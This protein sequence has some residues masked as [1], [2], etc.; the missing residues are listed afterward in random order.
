MNKITLR[1]YNREI[2][3]IT[4]QG[5]IDEAIAHCRHILKYFPKHVETYRLLGK[6]YL[7]NQRL[8]DAADIFQRVL[9][10]VPDDFVAHIG[11]SIIREDEGNLD[12]AIWHMQRAFDIQSAN[13]TIQDELRRL[14]GKRDGI[15]PPKIRLS[16]AALAR[17]YAQGDLVDQAI[18]DLRGALLEEPERMDLLVLL[19][20][21][22][23]ANGQRVKTA[24]TCSQIINKLPYC[25]EANLIL[26]QVLSETNRA[27]EAAAHLEK[28]RELD[29]YVAYLSTQAPTLDLVPEAAVSLIK[30]DDSEIR[31]EAASLQNKPAWASSLGMEVKAETDPQDS[32]DWLLSEDE[33]NTG[34]DDNLEASLA[35]SSAFGFGVAVASTSDEMATPDGDLLDFANNAASEEVIPDWMKEAGWEPRDPAK[36]EEN[37]VSLSPEAPVPPPSDNGD[38]APAEIPAWLQAMA[39]QELTGETA[40]QRIFPQAPRESTPP[41]TPSPNLA[42]TD[43]PDWL[44]AMENKPASA[45]EDDLDWLTNLTS[46]AT[47]TLPEAGV[48]PEAESLPDWLTD[49][50]RG[51]APEG[52]APSTSDLPDWLTLTDD[53]TS[54]ETPPAP[55]SAPDPTWFEGTKTGTWDTD[56]LS[57]TGITSWLEQLADTE[58]PPAPAE[59]ETED[60]FAPQAGQTQELALPK[61]ADDA[62]AIP[63]WLQGLDDALITSNETAEPGSPSPAENQPG[64]IPTDHIPAWLQGLDD[65]ILTSR[66]AAEDHPQTEVD[67]NQDNEMP[68]LPDMEDADAALR[69]LESLA[70]N[71]GAREE[72]LL[73]QPADRTSA[74][75]AWVQKMADDAN[76][77]D[78]LDWDA[79]PAEMEE[80]AKE[81]PVETGVPDWLSAEIDSEAEEDADAQDSGLAWLEGLAASQTNAA[82]E[83]LMPASD[84]ASGDEEADDWLDSL[85]DDVPA[86]DVEATP[87]GEDVPDWLKDALVDSGEASAEAQLPSWLADV[88]IEDDDEDV[89]ETTEEEAMPADIPDWLQQTMISS[90]PLPSAAEETEPLDDEMAAPSWL[91]TE[92]PLEEYA[93]MSATPAEDEIEDEMADL[94]SGEAP[95]ELEPTT[96]EEMPWELDEEEDEKSAEPSWL[97]EPM[98]D[99]PAE[100][101]PWSPGLTM[102]EED[103]PDME[104]VVPEPESRPS[105]DDRV[106]I[107]LNEAR[108]ALADGNIDSALIGYSVMIKKKDS[109]NRVIQDLNEALQYKHPVNVD[110]WQTLGDA[111]ARNEELQEALNAYTKAEELLR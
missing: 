59:P 101:I 1:G 43:L 64:G 29:P 65:E 66:P 87:I 26:S 67:M 10:A 8:G 86:G 23:R 50:D 33:T 81:M 28:A 25:L 90:A 73:T 110:I 72:E 68:E 83:D 94:W 32:V 19:A 84:F 46:K 44:S 42:G 100:T 48:T 53:D 58:P 22:Y 82:A 76:A 96:Q 47:A 61:P 92:K 104:E 17:M 36:P 21:M 37:P 57:G 97:P 15:E 20:R 38:L 4:D 55:E 85:V 3:A 103:T 102:A 34:I 13:I 75:P 31:V 108:N 14:Y 109:L 7:E 56:I 63:G 111:Y 74:P 105:S 2:E 27:E 5:K 40:P 99:Q 78:D 9:S 45:S 62:P 41:A 52:P 89:V 93:W 70:A 11:M 107:T 39:P 106:L 49:L 77:P 18:A 16:R 51:P 6:A 80:P 95:I 91:T 88:E 54:K 71:Q 98:E 35:T 60:L 12:A 69:W 24:Q 30:L 79:L